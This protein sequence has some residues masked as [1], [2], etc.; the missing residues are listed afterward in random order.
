M[1]FFSKGR[2]QLIAGERRLRAIKDN[3]GMTIIQAKM[4]DIDNLQANE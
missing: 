4:A 2:F 1:K 3:T